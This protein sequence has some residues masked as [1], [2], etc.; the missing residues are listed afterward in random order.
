[1]GA[2]EVIKLSSE[3]PLD[4]KKVSV[5][6]CEVCGLS[7]VN[8]K[9]LES[10]VQDKHTESDH[11][12][13]FPCELCGL[14]LANLILLQEHVKT[15]E[16]ESMACHKCDFTTTTKAFLREHTMEYHEEL[17]IMHTVAQQVEELTDRLTNSCT[18]FETFKTELSK[19]LMNLFDNQNII[20]QT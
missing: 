12:E 20:K 14:V 7:F 19:T 18:I 11:S 5:L 15:H 2:H 9:T 4:A 8:S 1:M 6:V 13:L 10:H 17:F 16:R 3:K